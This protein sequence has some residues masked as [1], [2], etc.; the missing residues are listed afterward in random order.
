M[1]V[2]LSAVGMAQ[3][4]EFNMKLCAPDAAGNLVPDDQSTKE[5]VQQGERHAFPVKIEKGQAYDLMVCFDVNESNSLQVMVK[6]ADT[7]ELLHANQSQTGTVL[8]QFI[9][10]EGRNINVYTHLHASKS[11]KEKEVCVGLGV[12]KRD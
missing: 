9:S 12:Y 8:I 2:A 4:D 1:I 5:L 3:C 11:Q 10:G 6:D 7:N